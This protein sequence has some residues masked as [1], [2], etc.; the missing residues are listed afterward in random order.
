[1]TE[2]WF[3]PGA[4]TGWRQRDS[5]EKRRRIVLRSRHGDNLAAGRALLAL[6][7]VNK[8]RNPETYRKARADADYFFRR[9]RSKRK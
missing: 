6:A 1:M 2:R 3:N 7:N 8:G 9:H 5:A 4:P